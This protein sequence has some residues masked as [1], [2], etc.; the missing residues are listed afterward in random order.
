[1]SK[2]SVALLDRLVCLTQLV[3]HCG[4]PVRYENVHGQHGEPR[5][6]RVRV[7]KI[8]STWI[9]DGWRVVT[10]VPNQ[11]SA[12]THDSADCAQIQFRTSSPSEFGSADGCKVSL[13]SSAP[14]AIQTEV[15]AQLEKLVEG[16]EHGI[17]LLRVAFYRMRY[18]LRLSLSR[19]DISSLAWSMMGKARS[20]LL[21]W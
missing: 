21:S 4:V 7:S 2:S 19:K 15:A 1:M 9:G 12:T 14:T 17:D 10:V 5:G 11:P 6:Y 20:P 3:R 16:A 8:I 18:S 13:L